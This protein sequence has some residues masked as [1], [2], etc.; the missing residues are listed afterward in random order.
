MIDRSELDIGDQVHAWYSHGE[1]TGEGIIVQAYIIGLG[2]QVACLLSNDPNNF[3]NKI[4]IFRYYKDLYRDEE[5]MNKIL[6]EEAT[7]LRK[8]ENPIYRAHPYIYTCECGNQAWEVT[9][10]HI[11]CTKCRKCR[12]NPAF[13]NHA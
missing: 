6:E 13:E 9:M 5:E 7:A 10:E 11:I 8:S 2:K 3:P 4:P 12:W 1:G